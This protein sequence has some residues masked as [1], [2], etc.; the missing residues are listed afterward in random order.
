MNV[1]PEIRFSACPHDCPDGCAMLFD[2]ED[3]KLVKVRGN[4]ANNYTTDRLCAKLN[5]YHEHHYNSDRLLYPMKRTGPKGGD[6]F[7]RISWD[8]ALSTIGEKWKEI[9]ATHGAHRPDWTGTEDCFLVS[10]AAA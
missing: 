9:I 3:G 2:V 8:E 6:S 10:G 5:D 1:K 4:P 7:E